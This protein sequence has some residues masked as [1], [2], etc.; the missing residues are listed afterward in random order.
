M[1]SI[2]LVVNQ[3]KIS[4]NQLKINDLE[5]KSMKFYKKSSFLKINLINLL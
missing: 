3:L 1:K 5:N 4:E 2:K